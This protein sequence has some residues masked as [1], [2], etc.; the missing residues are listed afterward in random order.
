MTTRI[1]ELSKDQANRFAEFRDKWVE[2]GLC[3]SPADRP[4]AEKAIRNMYKSAKLE[5]PTIIWCQSPLSLV[6]TRSLFLLKPMDSV[7][8]SVRASVRS[9]V[10]ASVWTSVYNSVC[11]NVLASIIGGVRSSVHSSVH[12]SVRDNILASVQDSVQTSVFDSVL[13]SVQARIYNSIQYSIQDSVQDSVRDSIHNSV[14]DS[15]RASVYG[16]HEA[17]WLAFYDFCRTVLSLKH[18]TEPLSGLFN[19]AA[20]CG[21][22][23][24]HPTICWASERHNVLSINDSGS[25]HCIDGPALSYPDGFS[26]Y[27]I[28]GTLIPGEWITKSL[29]SP[30]KL[31]HWKN[32]EQRRAGCELM[33]WDRLLSTLNATVIND[34]NNPGIG[35]LLEVNL[36]NSGRERFLSVKC[37]TG[38][39]FSIPVPVH[40]ET[41]HQANAW[42]WGVDKDKYNPEIRT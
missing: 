12:A 13:S 39:R 8:S 40:M 19:L 28:N 27:A 36:P 38:R 11:D 16:Q 42:T 3:T 41:A 14:R 25:L 32:I 20:S 23:L 35:K 15:I 7:H 5:E 24:P 17:H 21:W 22:I 6:L 9:S 2:I 29:P 37:G 34:S 26:I 30:D 4:V 10:R 18:E 33:G 1:N 31:L